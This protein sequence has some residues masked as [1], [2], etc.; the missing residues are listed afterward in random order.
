MWGH[1][2]DVVQDQFHFVVT[3][4][5]TSEIADKWSL[6][7]PS[8]LHVISLVIFMTSD[9][10]CQVPLDPVVHWLRTPHTL[11]SHS[12][13]SVFSWA[14][15]LVLARTKKTCVRSSPPFSVLS[16]VYSP[17]S[18]FQLTFLHPPVRVTVG[19]V[20]YSIEIDVGGE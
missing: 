20:R 3:S 4:E 12:V 8:D 14:P 18:F 17:F 9:F 19:E 16:D 6:V 10:T 7:M 2:H 1:S 11:A 13:M 5:T 15:L